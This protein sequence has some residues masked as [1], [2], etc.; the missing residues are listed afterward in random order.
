MKFTC[1]PAGE[2][3]PEHVA[4][5]DRM[6]RANPTLDSPFLRPEFTAAVAGVRSGIEVALIEDRDQIAGFFPFQRSRWNVGKPVG[7]KMC[8]VQG[9]I[10]PP[11][12]PC[13]VSDMIRAC[14]L[15]AWDFNG[16]PADQQP[17]Q[18]FHDR[19]EKNAFM[20]L[21]QGFEAYRAE[22]RQ[23]GSEK[24]KQVLKLRRK[25]EREVGPVRFEPYATCPDAWPLLLRWKSEQYRRTRSVDVLAYRWTVELLER[26]RALRSAAFGGMLSA[27]YIG[28]RLAAV[29]LGLRSF[30][31]NHAWFT[32]YDPALSRYSPGAMLTVA[33]AEA[34]AELGIRRVDLG[35]ITDMEYKTSFMTGTQ[36]VARG[37]VACRPL[38]RLIRRGWSRTRTWLKSSSL[39]GP[40]GIAAQWIRPLRGWLALR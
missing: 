27:L 16:V 34:A 22:R 7:R 39:R 24:I 18:A 33:L 36:A 31:V 13:D 25:A 11:C 10:A 29:E 19:L 17:F 37:S 40:A 4:T 35:K 26:I 30:H 12:L 5:W 6:Q 38:T 8:D 20:D 21:S 28:D 23:S 9:L 32:A 2:L 15:S 1:I 14:R 3:S